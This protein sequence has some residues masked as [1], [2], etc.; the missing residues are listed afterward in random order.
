MYKYKSLQADQ[1]MREH[2]PFL[3]NLLNFVIKYLKQNVDDNEAPVSITRDIKIDQYHVIK[4]KWHYNTNGE[5][6]LLL[7][8]FDNNKPSVTRDKGIFKVMWLW[9][10]DIT[11]SL[12]GVTTEILWIWFTC[13][14]NLMFLAFPWLEI[15]QF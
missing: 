2:L 3:K 7:Q 9:G 15:C 6:S 1:Q 4:R 14:A 5:V 12:G 10:N 8:K 11:Y 13:C